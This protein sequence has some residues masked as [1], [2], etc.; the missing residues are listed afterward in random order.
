LQSPPLYD[1]YELA[2]DVW[3]HSEAALTRRNMELL[4]E[5]IRLYPRRLKLV[6]EAA[7]LNAS[8][9]FVAEATALIDRGVGLTSD[10]AV[11]AKFE[12][13]R[14]TFRAKSAP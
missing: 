6:Y 3:M 4:D 9:G 8:N 13:L 10:P 2:G 1:L 12:E 7:L 5:G 14:S 11:R